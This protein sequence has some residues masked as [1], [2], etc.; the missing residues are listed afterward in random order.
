MEPSRI[1]QRFTHN[2]L[3]V[4]SL[5]YLLL[6][7]GVALFASRLAPISPEE[8][9]ILAKLSAPSAKHLL[10]ADHLGRDI[11]SRLI[12]GSQ[13]SL[14]V[15]LV[16]V[17]ISIVVGVL[18]GLISAFYGGW[19]DT[20]LMR[21]T[22]GMLAI[23]VLFLLIAVLSVFD[24][25]LLSLV[26][27]IGLTRWM[28]PARI[29]RAEILKQRNQDYVLAA[30][31]I[32]APGRRILFTHLLPQAIPSLIV[33]AT[34]GIAQAILIES[35]VSYLGLGIQPPT[36]SWGNMLTGA[37]NYI[38]IAPSLA[39]YPGLSIFFTVLAYN[40]FGDGLRDALDPRFVQS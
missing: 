7:Y 10:G 14:S 4:I 40:S 20:I 32:G 13:A 34:F 28:A 29:V 30:Q 6:M 1:W 18:V 15:G 11:L 31:A 37:Q 16:A 35:A 2:R 38:W 21:I 3:A 12:Y 17:L 26:V 24:R 22:D 23:P 8:L 5:V 36:P 25:T 27:F 33:T 19:I 9:D 39:L